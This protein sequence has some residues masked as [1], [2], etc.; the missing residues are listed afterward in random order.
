MG[1]IQAT[2]DKDRGQGHREAVILWGTPRPLNEDQMGS[3]RV[4]QC[5]GVLNE[6]CDLQQG[7]EGRKM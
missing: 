5:K 4:G 6:P 7:L 3:Q 1:K 2:E